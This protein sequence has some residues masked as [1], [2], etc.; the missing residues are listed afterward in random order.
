MRLNTVGVACEHRSFVLPKCFSC[1][2]IALETIHMRKSRFSETRDGE[3]R[4]AVVRAKQLFPSL[5]HD[6]ARIL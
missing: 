2:F 1:H 4:D 5:W 6:V 3:K